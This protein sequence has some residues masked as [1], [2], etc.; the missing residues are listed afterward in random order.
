MPNTHRHPVF[1]GGLPCQVV[2]LRLLERIQGL[3]F[4]AGVL[5]ELPSST[6][7]NRFMFA[8]LVRCAVLQEPLHQRCL[9]HTWIP[10]AGMLF[11]LVPSPKP[12]TLSP[13]LCRLLARI[14]NHSSHDYERFAWT[15]RSWRVL[16]LPCR[17]TVRSS[18]LRKLG[19]GGGGVGPF[20]GEQGL[21]RNCTAL[22]SRL[23]LFA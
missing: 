1:W 20:P 16:L 2:C 18:L 6:D 11:A 19:G 4:R 5:F 22:P 10:A 3:G 14:H 17:R 12:K 15:S 23:C 7:P 8:T 9:G 21:Y 13:K